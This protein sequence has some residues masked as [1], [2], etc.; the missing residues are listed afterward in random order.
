MT[1]SFEI[2]MFDNGLKQRFLI[3]RLKIDSRVL[4]AGVITDILFEEF[5][6]LAP[7]FAGSAKTVL[8]EQL[9]FCSNMYAS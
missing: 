1:K 8:N 4:G 9:Q 5:K 6:C 7:N 3:N 2:D